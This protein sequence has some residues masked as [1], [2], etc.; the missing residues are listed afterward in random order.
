L[1]FNRDVELWF[2]SLVDSFALFLIGTRQDGDTR[3]AIDFTNLLLSCQYQ[4]KFLFSFP[5]ELVILFDNDTERVITNY[6]TR[7][8]S[9]CSSSFSEPMRKSDAVLVGVF[10]SIQNFR[11]VIGAD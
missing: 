4:K 7:F 10:K 3:R 2:Y 5:F 11:V 8:F 6:S 9:N 1:N